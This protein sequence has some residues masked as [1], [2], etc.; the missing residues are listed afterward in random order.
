MDFLDQQLNLENSREQLVLRDL[1]VVLSMLVAGMA[2]CLEL[3]RV[4]LGRNSDMGEACILASSIDRDV[5][6]GPD[7]QKLI[8]FQ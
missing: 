3:G 6:V 5:N 1:L 8:L 4:F 2:K 7:G